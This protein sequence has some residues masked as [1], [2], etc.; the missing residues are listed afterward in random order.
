MGERGEYFVTNVYSGKTTIPKR[1]RELLDI[2][3]NDKLVW[4]IRPNG[5]VCIYKLK[6]R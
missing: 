1:I 5:E 4:E 6:P 2:T 3:D